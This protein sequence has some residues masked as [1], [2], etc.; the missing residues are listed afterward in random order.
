MPL[1]R[2]RRGLHRRQEIS[3]SP[4]EKHAKSFDLSAA[5]DYLEEVIAPVTPEICAGFESEA[6][7]RLH[8]RDEDDWPVLAT[9]LAL[10]CAVWTEIKKQA[11]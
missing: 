1:L 2:T 6:R 9:A 5:F 10:G 11:K 4:F 3:A 7:L 8:G